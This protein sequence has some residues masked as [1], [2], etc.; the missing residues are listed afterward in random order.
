[1]LKS[2]NIEHNNNTCDNSRI[3]S[4][5]NLSN[6]KVLFVGESVIP[7]FLQFFWQ[8]YR[9][10]CLTSQWRHP[11]S[12]RTIKVKLID[13]VYLHITV[14]NWNNIFYNSCIFYLYKILLLET[15]YWK[16]QWFELTVLN[17]QLFGTQIQRVNSATK[18]SKSSICVNIKYKVFKQI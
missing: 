16:W 18:Y 11:K 10:L 14:V 6:W 5:V 17:I 7:T 4:V 8:K 15:R 1:M 13:T 3:S 9:M 2:N 12:S